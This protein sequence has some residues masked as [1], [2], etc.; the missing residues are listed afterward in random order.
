MYDVFGPTPPDLTSSCGQSV[1]NASSWCQLMDT[2]L[3]FSSAIT[4]QLQKVEDRKAAQ[5]IREPGWKGGVWGVGQGY[6]V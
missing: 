1:T 3:Q 2:R 5:L 6:R 4:L